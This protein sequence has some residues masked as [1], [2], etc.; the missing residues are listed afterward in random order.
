MHLLVQVGE[1][2]ADAVVSAAT[3]AMGESMMLLCLMEF[4]EY[5]FSDSVLYPP[6]LVRVST[7]Y[8]FVVLGFIV[9]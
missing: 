3:C 4:A 7:L 9:Q 1:D 5:K 2:P 8:Q 6:L